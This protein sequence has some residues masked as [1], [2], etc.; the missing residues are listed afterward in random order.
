MQPHPTLM[1]PQVGTPS[2]SS[3]A[4]SRFVSDGL[5]RPIVEGLRE[6]A[7]NFTD[8]VSALSGARQTR[9]RYR[10]PARDCC[11]EPDPC[12]CTCC[13]VD[14]DLIIHA[15]LGERRVVPLTIENRWRRERKVKVELSGWSTRGGSPATVNA[16]LQPPGP[17]FTL[18]PCGQ[19]ELVLIVEAT[20]ESDN[21]RRMPDVDDCVVYYA[22]LRVEGCEIRPIRIALALLPRDC[23][24]YRIECRCQ[25]C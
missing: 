10:K 20:A 1:L 19:Q 24:A 7:V 14:A 13:I 18:P 3:D 16:R 9:A 2:V 22:D 5:I 25:C 12:H 11:D 21:E 23:G 4:V 17:E 15:R 6:A 8:S